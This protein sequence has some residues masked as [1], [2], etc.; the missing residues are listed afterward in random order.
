MRT[1]RGTN[2]QMIMAILYVFFLVGHIVDFF[3]AETCS[4]NIRNIICVINIV[5][6][7]MTSLYS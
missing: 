5:V 4:Y 3:Y 2:I 7:D 1:R 6:S